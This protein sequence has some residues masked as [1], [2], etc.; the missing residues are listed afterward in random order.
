MGQYGFHI[1]IRTFNDHFYWLKVPL[2]RLYRIIY[3]IP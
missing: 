3:I 2:Y 1:H